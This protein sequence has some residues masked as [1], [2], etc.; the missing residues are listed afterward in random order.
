MTSNAE[1]IPFDDVIMAWAHF[2]SIT[3]QGPG[4][5]EKTLHVVHVIKFQAISICY[6]LINAKIVIYSV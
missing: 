6:L 3:E 2:S 4:Q 1:M 5:L